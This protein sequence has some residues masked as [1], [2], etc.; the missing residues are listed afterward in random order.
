MNQANLREQLANYFN[1]SE[2]NDLCFDLNID[3]ENLPDQTKQEKVRELIIYCQR[4]RLMEELIMRCQELRPQVSWEYTKFNH[5]EI[6]EDQRAKRMNPALI[7]SILM[8]MFVLVM[9]AVTI[10]YLLQNSIFASTSPSIEDNEGSIESTS[11]STP[12]LPP[13]SSSLEV[14]RSIEA[15]SIIPTSTVITRPVELP[16]GA[17][18]KMISPYGYEYQYTILSAQRESLPPDSYLLHLRIRAWS[19]QSGGLNL[20]RN[21]FRLVDGDR[22]LAPVNFLNEVVAQNATGDGDVKFE[23]D[24]SLA[25]A[26]LVITA[27]A[28][29]PGNSKELRLLFP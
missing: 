26:V 14:T 22:K 15:P 16:D 3:Y 13:L 18:V 6:E 1:E 21:S 9:C 5:P 12:N 24:S 29:F 25:E 10:A 7:L 11:V 28:D 8:G 19:D 4:H 20:M 27:G 17:S 23:I 2:L